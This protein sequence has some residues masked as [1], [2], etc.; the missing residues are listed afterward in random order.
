MR[1]VPTTK[2][3]IEII[4]IIKPCFFSFLSSFVIRCNPTTNP[5]APETYN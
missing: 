1:K 4:N 3:K 5:I 2:N